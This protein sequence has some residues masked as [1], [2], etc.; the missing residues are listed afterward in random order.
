MRCQVA[1]DVITS[2]PYW[3]VSP[4]F[5]VTRSNGSRDRRMGCGS[6]SQPMKRVSARGAPREMSSS[7]HDLFHSTG[8][9]RGFR[10]GTER[11]A[12]NLYDVSAADSVDVTDV[13]TDIS[14]LY[15]GNVERQA[16]KDDYQYTFSTNSPS[17]MI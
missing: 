16:P 1:R 10:R 11:A 7:S 4:S 17:T 14:P 5:V 15:S 13:K 2:E 12:R 9:C 8:R 3:K 6:S